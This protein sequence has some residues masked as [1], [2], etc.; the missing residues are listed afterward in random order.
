MYIIPTLLLTGWNLV[1][2]MRA[3]GSEKQPVDLIAIAAAAAWQRT[4]VN[5]VTEIESQHLHCM[6]TPL[7]HPKNSGEIVIRK[8]RF[9]KITFSSLF[10]LFLLLTSYTLYAHIHRIPSWQ[11]ARLNCAPT[12]QAGSI[13]GGTLKEAIASYSSRTAA[14]PADIT[15]CV[16]ASMSLYR[17]SLIH[18]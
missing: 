8:G 4:G 13:D 5:Q 9:M 16:L 1:K 7:S 14:A 17:L 3:R 11:Q 15:K 2:R 12:R 18:I 10:L 6:P